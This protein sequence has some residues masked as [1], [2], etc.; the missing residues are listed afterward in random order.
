MSTNTNE[1]PELRLPDCPKCGGKVDTTAAIDEKEQVIIIASCQ[2]CQSIGN[3]IAEGITPDMLDTPKP[4]TDT[5][6]AW[7]MAQSTAIVKIA[8]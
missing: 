5:V 3:A 7:L 2:S 4:S 6:K 8:E 1:K